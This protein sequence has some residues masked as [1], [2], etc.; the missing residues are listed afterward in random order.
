MNDKQKKAKRNGNECGY[1]HAAENGHCTGLTKRE[2]IAVA[3]M[4][5][6]LAHPGPGSVDMNGCVKM[7]DRLLLALEDDDG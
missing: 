5:G 1:G 7:A 6:M 2:V 4:Q 3:V